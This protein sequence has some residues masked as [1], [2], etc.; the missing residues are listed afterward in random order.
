M[1]RQHTEASKRP[2][3]EAILFQSLFLIRSELERLEN[4]HADFKKAISSIIHHVDELIELMISDY[5]ESLFE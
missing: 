1:K 5:E 3:D 4:E 2:T